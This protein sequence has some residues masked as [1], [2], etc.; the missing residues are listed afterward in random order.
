VENLTGLMGLPYPIIP[1]FT[2]NPNYK[3]DILA[4]ESG[5]VKL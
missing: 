1:I 4:N 3:V 5:R 2:L